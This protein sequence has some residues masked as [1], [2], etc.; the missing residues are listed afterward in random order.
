[1]FRYKNIANKLKNEKVMLFDNP[2]N[3]KTTSFISAHNSSI[4]DFLEFS[5]N[6]GLEAT[7]LYLESFILHHASVKI[8]FFITDNPK[9][10]GISGIGLKKWDFPNEFDQ[11]KH[12]VFS[13]YFETL[14][15]YVQLAFSSKYQR[16]AIGSVY[17]EEAKF[18]H[19]M[20]FATY[21]TLRDMEDWERYSF[22][23]GFMEFVKFN[24]LPQ[25]MA[26]M[27]I[28]KFVEYMPDLD[29]NYNCKDID[30]LGADF[31]NALERSNDDRFTTL[32]DPSKYLPLKKG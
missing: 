22:L 17:S 3:D 7:E 2:I 4:D 25:D 19:S 29:F 14:D 16:G 8:S 18:H 9:P 27:N 28:Q 5:D 1:M 21:C 26:I 13:Q 6:S 20:F 32:N 24:V 23:L 15:F 12:S 31:A 30:K 11:V 10:E